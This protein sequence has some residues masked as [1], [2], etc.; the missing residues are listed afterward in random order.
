MTLSIG[1][2]AP[3]FAA[4]DQNNKKVM[5]SDFRGRHVILYFYPKDFTPGCTKEACSFQ[6][7]MGVFKKHKI[8]VLGVSTDTV[9]SHKEFA[10]KHK[11]TYQ[12]LSDEDKKIA[13]L[14]DVLGVM[15]IVGM[16][17]RITYVIDKDGIIEEVFT[18]VKPEEHA[19]DLAEI[20]KARAQ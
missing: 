12:L 3:D 2:T 15:G 8:V 9:Q 20:F 10:K 19:K 4:K 11:L 18:D 5:L 13:K 16:S 7:N 1:T 6:E 14:Y 17:K